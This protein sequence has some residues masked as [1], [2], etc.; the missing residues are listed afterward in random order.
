M[1]ENVKLKSRHDSGT[2]IFDR[3][4]RPLVLDLVKVPL[5]AFRCGLG[6][7][8]EETSTEA[9]CCRIRDGFDGAR[10]PGAKDPLTAAANAGLRAIYYLPGCPSRVNLGPSSSV[11]RKRFQK[12]FPTVTKLVQV[13][14]LMRSHVSGEVSKRTSPALSCLGP[15]IHNLTYFTTPDQEG[16]LQRVQPVFT[17]SNKYSPADSHNILAAYGTTSPTQR[18]Y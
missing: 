7:K 4:S 9:M 5:A 16:D 10:L 14:V 13:V 8:L 12:M 11:C 17:F 2:M 1:V 6:W 18:R 15:A 3:P